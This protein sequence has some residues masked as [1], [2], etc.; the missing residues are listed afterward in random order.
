MI[1]GLSEKV[2]FIFVNLKKRFVAERM[3]YWTRFKDRMSQKLISYSLFVI[4]VATIN[5]Y[6]VTNVPC[7]ET[8]CFYIYGIKVEEGFRLQFVVARSNFIWIENNDT[9]MISEKNNSK[10][11]FSVFTY[12]SFLVSKIF[13]KIMLAY[14]S[15]IYLNL[16]ILLYFILCKHEWK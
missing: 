8:K 11:F 2:I 14:I 16:N 10:N 5:S 3:N 13:R 7:F 12:T 6:W 15:V 4:L 1:N 9:N